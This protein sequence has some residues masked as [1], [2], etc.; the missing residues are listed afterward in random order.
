MLPTTFKTKPDSR[1]S[2]L[3]ELVEINP[4][5]STKVMS[6]RVFLWSSELI[7]QLEVHLM[8]PAFLRT[9]LIGTQ[10]TGFFDETLL[11]MLPQCTKFICHIGAS[12]DSINTESCVTLGANRSICKICLATQT[13]QMSPITRRPL[14]LCGWY[15]DAYGEYRFPA[16]P[17]VMGIGVAQWN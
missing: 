11:H 6:A 1:T 2:T 5:D 17:S 3:K 15:S 12:Y 9:T 4:S 16:M 13:R 7:N 10:M 14:L 8:K